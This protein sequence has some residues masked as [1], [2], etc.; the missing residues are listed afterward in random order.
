MGSNLLIL[1]LVY[2]RTGTMFSV[3]NSYNADDAGLLL[4]YRENL[5]RATRLIAEHFRRLGLTVAGGIGIVVVS[6]RDGTTGNRNFI[7]SKHHNALS[8]YSMILRNNMRTY[9]IIDHSKR[10]TGNS[11]GSFCPTKF[12][13][14]NTGNVS[15]RVQW[16]NWQTFDALCLQLLRRRVVGRMMYYPYIGSHTHKLVS[17]YAFAKEEQQ[18]VSKRSLSS[19]VLTL[20][21][22]ICSRETYPLGA[23][24]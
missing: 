10:A 18:K 21:T 12:Q 11:A 3:F 8:F 17:C 2:G 22:K 7:D 23:T 6:R 5:T 20:A 14:Y 1:I 16:H 9:I 24:E 15:Q 13:T 4:L 19:K